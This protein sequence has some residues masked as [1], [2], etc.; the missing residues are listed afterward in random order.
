MLENIQQVIDLS[1]NSAAAIVGMLLVSEIFYYAD[2]LGNR[3]IITNWT[4]VVCVVLFLANWPSEFLFL[5]IVFSAVPF[6]CNLFDIFHLSGK[7]KGYQI[8]N[9]LETIIITFLLGASIFM[10]A[11]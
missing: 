11:S 10:V 5:K 2:C 3:Q 7:E 6:V 9:I 8:V 4:S 1:V